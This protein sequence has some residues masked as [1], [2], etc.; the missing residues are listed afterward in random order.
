[1]VES[2]LKRGWSLLQIEPCKELDFEMLSQ[3]REWLS[4]DLMPAQVQ[5]VLLA[6]KKIPED[7]LVGWCEDVNWITEYDW[8]YRTSFVREKDRKFTRKNVGQCKK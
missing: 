3:E 4:I 7:F 6:H 8:V 2:V 5:D 1:M